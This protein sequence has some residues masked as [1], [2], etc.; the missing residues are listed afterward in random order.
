[1]SQLTPPPRAFDHRQGSAEA[2]LVLVEYGDF[3]CPFCR[4]AH[5]IVQAV[6]RRLS[7]ELQF[8][9]RHFPLKNL[10]PHAEL[11]AEAAEAAAAQ[12]KF[13][14]MHDALYENQERL[15]LLLIQTLAERLELDMNRFLRELSDHTYRE[16][17]KKDFMSGVHSGANGTPT[18]FING[19]RFTDRWDEE[20]LSAALLAT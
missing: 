5:F 9:Y 13:W 15:D 20:S 10:H 1:M 6:Q 4:Q 14:A 11:A 2:P 7:D 19:T 16:R 12:G 17:I 18:F 3:E 8:V